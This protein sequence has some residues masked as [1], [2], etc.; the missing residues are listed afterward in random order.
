VGICSCRRRHLS[1]GSG[2]GGA[3]WW[4]GVRCG[5]REGARAPGRAVVASM[6][7]GPPLWVADVEA[8]GRG[9]RGVVDG[10]GFL[11]GSGAGMDLEASLAEPAGA[12]GAGW[13]GR[14]N[15]GMG[16]GLAAILRGWGIGLGP[17]RPDGGGVY[18]FPRGGGVVVVAV[19]F[20]SGIRFC[21][22]GDERAGGNGAGGGGESAGRVG[23]RVGAGFFDLPADGGSAGGLLALDLAEAFEA[24]AARAGFGPALALEFLAAGPWLSQGPCLFLGEDAVGFLECF[25]GTDVVPE[26]GNLPGVD[27][28]AG[29]EPLDEA[30][31]LVGVVSLGHIL[32]DHGEDCL[33]VIIESD[34]G[35]GAGRVFR[36]FLEE[37]NA[38]LLVEGDGVI[39]FDILEAADVIDAEDRGVFLAAKGAERL[40]A[41]IKEI[42]TGDDNEVV[43]DLA[44]LQ[45]EMD[46]PDGAEFIAVIG[47][48]V[49]DYG[50]G[51]ARVLLVVSIGPLLEVTGEFGVG[52]DV[53]A[54]DIRDGS[55]VIEHILDHGFAG[56]LEQGFGLGQGEG[57]EASGITGGQDQHFHGFTE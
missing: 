22:A 50:K 2:A 15:R 24:A 8:I 14:I 7:A 28:G 46:I 52:D 44:L 53:D 48:A 1:V 19:A 55:E 17:G 18:C 27:G 38:A 33:G 5:K 34:A 16:R 30:P 29:V 21:A 45:D 36:L 12:D 3:L 26:A 39:F 42:I 49:I 40:E 57:V 47:G 41:F 20:G 31:G 37:N 56:N 43:I 32:M 35:E 54:I 51:C 6:V 10:V 11:G 4:G 25:L 13:R 9:T 23:T